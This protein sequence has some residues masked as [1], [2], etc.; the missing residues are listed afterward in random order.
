MDEAEAIRKKSARSMNG[1]LCGYLKT[2]IQFARAAVGALTDRAEDQGSALYNKVRN[3]EL[4]RQVRALERSVERLKEDLR[5]SEERNQ[6]LRARLRGFE[7]RLGSLSLSMEED[8]N[9][10][11]A[12]ES[13]RAR[14]ETRRREDVSGPGFPGGREKG[15]LTEHAEILRMYDQ[16]LAEQSKLLE[17]AIAMSRPAGAEDQKASDMPKK[18]DPRIISDVQIA[19]PRH[20]VDQVSGAASAESATE[21]PLWR[22]VGNARPKRPTDR[23]RS[24]MEAG[25]SLTTPGRGRKERIPRQAKPRPGN[26]VVVIKTKEDNKVPYSEILK[27]ARQRM[28]I[29]ELG[30]VDPRIRLAASGGVLL[31]IAGPEGHARADALA[32]KIKLALNEEVEVSRPVKFGELRLKGIDPS[33]SQDEIINILATAGGCAPGQVRLR[34][35]RR[36]VRGVQS[37]WAK[38]PLSSAFKLADLQKIGAGWSVMHVELLRSRPTQCYKCWGY[39]HVR[40]MCKAN[41]DK[42]GNC[43]NCGEAGHSIGNCS[44]PPKCMVCKESNKTFNH[45]MG[46]TICSSLVT[47][48]GSNSNRYRNIQSVTD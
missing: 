17:Q 32:N 1:A 27:M 43:F 18:K 13:I 33:V 4:E 19:S 7:E 47:A 45:R 31:E 6:E 41:V 2:R 35:I 37:V 36:N 8:G 24:N 3:E 15:L 14:K 28:D 5:Q 30:I 29:K 42:S 34:P 40:S 21:S 38:C 16:R 11:G 22:A 46:S 10:T 12:V 39:G 26:A 23:F 44:S 25:S 20:A 9:N 48:R